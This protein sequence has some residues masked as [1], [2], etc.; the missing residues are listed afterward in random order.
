VKRA[1]GRGRAAMSA[2][3][4]EQLINTCHCHFRSLSL[5]IGSRTILERLSALHTHTRTHTHTHKRAH[6]SKSE[7]EVMWPLAD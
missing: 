2:V 6:A 5:V 3:Q 4:G 1:A 7:R